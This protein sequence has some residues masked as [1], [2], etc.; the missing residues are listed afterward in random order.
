VETSDLICD[1]AQ[2]F[3]GFT[4]GNRHRD[5]EVR[6]MPLT[7]SSQRGKHRCPGCNS[8]INNDD[9]SASNRDC[10]P[11][12]E[13]EGAATLELGESGCLCVGKVLRGYA[14]CFYQLLV[15]DEL[16]VTNISD[17]AK[18]QLRLARCA[19]L[20]HEEK[21][22]RGVHHTRDLKCD[23]YTAARQSENDGMPA[24]PR[25]ETGGELAASIGAI[26]EY[27][28]HSRSSDDE[29]GL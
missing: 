19:D 15:N 1:S 29:L 7:D 24:A 14:E 10:W 17:S 13:V 20:A 21:V 12:P 25:T 26:P 27:H 5:H 23:L 4:R 28:G 9:R 6:G 3:D 11:I 8:I 2:S 16:R 18:R 22:E